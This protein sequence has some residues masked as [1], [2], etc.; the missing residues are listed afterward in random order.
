VP[1][2]R[3]IAAISL[4]LGLV[5][6][7]AAADQDG[8]MRV[9]VHV[10]A[11]AD[12]QLLSR[13]DGQVADLDVTLVR[14]HSAALAATAEAQYARARALARQHRARIVV[15][16]EAAGPDGVRVHV[17]EPGRDTLFA[18]RVATAD[19]SA[20][21][22]AIAIVVRT[23]LQALAAGGEIGVKVPRPAPEPV[24]SPPSTGWRWSLGVQGQLSV[25]G[26]SSPGQAGLLGRADLSR[27]RVQLG[28]AGVVGIGDELRDPM[29]AVHLTRH[30]GGVGVAF[31][32]LGGDRGAVWIG[33][34]AGLLVYTRSTTV[35][36]GGLEAAP[37]TST[38]AGFAAPRVRG[39]WRP[40]A[41][42]AL[43]LTCEVAAAVVAG[44]PEL[45]YELDGQPVVRNRL[46]PVQPSVG[47]GLRLEGL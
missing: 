8:P 4:V 17:A 34:D 2:L 12:R 23:T 39:Q 28:V 40:L 13:I 1:R 35:L 14:D 32:A 31:R 24:V 27:A 25:D 29:T 16:F 19:E 43:W 26:A 7:A 30:G 6:G 38:V 15:W 9:V 46:W 44:A 3:F 42:Q 21:A 45:R 20:R 18:R 11:A 10:A 33:I 5:N 36:S 22:E 47:L 37:P 41:D